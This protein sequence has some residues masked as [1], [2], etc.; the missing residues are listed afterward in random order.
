MCTKNDVYAIMRAVT[1]AS[2]ALLGDRLD[3]VVLYGSYARGDYDEESDVDVMIRIRCP[4]EE[5]ALYED[6]FSRLC[7]RLSLEYDV[8]VSIVAVSAETYARFRQ[9]LPF[10]LNTEREGIRFDR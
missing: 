4:Q 6:A 5:L 8:T 3:A 1:E 2:N 7:S 10:Y 9:V